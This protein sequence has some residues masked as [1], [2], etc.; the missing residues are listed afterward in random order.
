MVAKSL[1]LQVEELTERV[2]KLDKAMIGVAEHI[3]GACPK[4]KNCDGICPK[5]GE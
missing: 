3:C 5:K 4:N 2:D 1:E